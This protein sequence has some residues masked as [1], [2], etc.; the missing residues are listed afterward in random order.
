MT[1]G[2]LIPRSSAAGRIHWL[3]IFY[4]GVATFITK[5]D[6]RV[7]AQGIYDKIIANYE[8]KYGVEQ[9]NKSKGD[10]VPGQS[11]PGQGGRGITGT[12]QAIA[13]QRTAL[14]GYHEG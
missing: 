3:I 13:S 7:V 9:T 11:V 8:Q 12:S 1:E 14:D 5:V 6:D 10:T 4:L 2:G